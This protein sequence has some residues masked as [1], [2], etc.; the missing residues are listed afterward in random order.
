MK[1]VWL[2]AAAAVLALSV[3]TGCSGT[4]ELPDSQPASRPN[5][6]TSS[7]SSAAGS[8]A[9]SS[10]SSSSSSNSSSASSKDNGA[11]SASSST[12]ASSK[13]EETTPWKYQKSGSSVTITG[14]D[15]ELAGDVTI[16]SKIGDDTV[17]AIGN[18]AFKGNAKITS[19][20]IP[21]GVIRIGMEAFQECRQLARVTLPS[22]LTNIGNYAFFCEDSLTTLT[23]PGSVKEIGDHTF[24]GCK[25]LKTLTLQEG[26][27]RIG[28]C[29]FSG[30]ESLTEVNLPS[31]LNYIETLAFATCK[32][33][34]QIVIPENSKGQ[35]TVMQHCAF[36]Y[37]QKLK[38]VYFPKTLKKID[39]PFTFMTSVD[40]IYYGGTKEDWAKINI[41]DGSINSTTVILYAQKPA[42]INTTPTVPE[43][44]DDFG[45]PN[46][47]AELYAVRQDVLSAFNVRRTKAGLTP[48]RMNLVALN[49]VAQQG[50]VARYNRDDFNVWQALGDNKVTYRKGNALSGGSLYGKSGLL[51]EI[52]RGEWDEDA[53]NTA[54]KK[55]GIGWYDGFYCIIFIG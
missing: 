32:N 4:G 28:N 40:Y 37:C 15:G 8:N 34:E 55:V 51:S 30:C 46:A 9:S 20:T 6:G 27:E 43:E 3:L 35:E 21:E 29:A 48:L 2:T 7:S 52:Q 44:P 22:T 25:N 39:N 50:S 1:R 54:F 10:G 19:V 36:Q 42:D 13:P 16:P 18:N 49:E 12:A 14:Y 53:L 23:I 5:G 47:N 33:L 38:K 17:I 24:S 41:T 45:D 11:N 31:T 26:V